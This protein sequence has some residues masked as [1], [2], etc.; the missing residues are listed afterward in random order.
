[1][2][3]RDS[4]LAFLFTSQDKKTPLSENQLKGVCLLNHNLVHTIIHE[5]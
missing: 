1:M 5:F 2:P 3:V 4:R